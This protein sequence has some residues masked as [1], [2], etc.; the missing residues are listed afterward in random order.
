MTALIRRGNDADADIEK[1]SDEWRVGRTGSSL[2]TVVLILIIS[3]TQVCRTSPVGDPNWRE[4]LRT[5]P[6]ALRLHTPDPSEEQAAMMWNMMQ[7]Q[8]MY[9]EQRRYET[10]QLRYTV[11]ALVTP[12]THAP[13][14]PPS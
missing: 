6:N 3:L 8:Q 1:D 10:E 12:M 2:I 4:T 7:W 13:V 5:N 11:A 9:E 14:M